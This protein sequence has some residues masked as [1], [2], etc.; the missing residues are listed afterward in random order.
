MQTDQQLVARESR[1]SRD[2]ARVHAWALAR[3]QSRLYQPTSLFRV[4]PPPTP[5]HSVSPNPRCWYR[6]TRWSASNQRQDPS[7]SFASSYSWR[8]RVEGVVLS[9]FLSPPLSFVLQSPALLSPPSFSNCLRRRFNNFDPWF[10]F[11]LRKL[12]TSPKLVLVVPFLYPF[13]SLYAYV[14]TI[15]YMKFISHNYRNFFLN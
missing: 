7:S 5:L 6:E 15:Y 14:L 8:M 1:N 3:R 4:L 12:L 2:G 11:Y 10:W 13:L 9:V